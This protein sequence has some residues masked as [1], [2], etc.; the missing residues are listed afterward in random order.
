MLLKIKEESYD[1]QN[2][3]SK[4]NIISLKSQLKSNLKN[5]TFKEFLIDNILY[6]IN[7]F[8][9]LYTKE[10]FVDGFVLY[11]KYSRK[12]VFRILNWN[13]NPLAQNV[14]GYIVSPDKS[15]F[16]IF[17]NYHKE[18]H[19]SSTTKYDDGFINKF[20]FQWMSKS[21]RNLNSPDIQILKNHE[22]LRIPLFIKKSN[23]EGTDF[24]YI[25]DITPIEN[26][27][28]QSTLN[29]DN[30]KPVSVVKVVFSM[31]TPVEDNIYDYITEN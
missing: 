15:N 20:E 7:T 31:N 24:Y 5:S 2:I 12:D 17:V 8:N 3:E 4:N 11:R 10:K 13:S 23:D 29:D 9:K 28:I 14:G 6:S 16:P 26:S 25:G 22:N 21:K 18:E 27:F 30:G 19:I 1:I